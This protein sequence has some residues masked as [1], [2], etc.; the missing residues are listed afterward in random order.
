[1]LFWLR[2]FQRD[3]IYRRLSFAA[4]KEG[5]PDSFFTA[6]MLLPESE[7]TPLDAELRDIF[8]MSCEKGFRAILDQAPVSRHLR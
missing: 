6:W 1:M 2:Y 5:E 8:E 3:G 4:V 7:R